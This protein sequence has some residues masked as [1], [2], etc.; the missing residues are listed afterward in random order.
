MSAVR[1]GCLAAG[2]RLGSRRFAAKHT[3]ARGHALAW[4]RPDAPA[5]QLARP[6]DAGFRH[7]HRRA[8]S[9]LT[10]PHL[11]TPCPPSQR[12]GDM[13]LT[14]RWAKRTRF[15][16]RL[17]VLGAPLQGATCSPWPFEKPW[18]LLVCSSTCPPRPPTRGATCSPW[19]F[20]KP[21]GL[22]VCPTPCP[23]RHG[24]IRVLARQPS[25]SNAVFHYTDGAHQT[26]AAHSFP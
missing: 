19:P 18:G 24:K 15:G 25:N 4:L 3:Q 10:A 26:P 13:F 2:R 20:G 14:A 6:T 23:L 9:H 1:P 12:G 7:A 16:V 21:W 5:S 8:A 22:H 17:H 11:P